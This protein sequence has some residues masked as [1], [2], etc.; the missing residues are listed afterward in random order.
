MVYRLNTNETLSHCPAHPNA[1]DTNTICV[2]EPNDTENMSD[3]ILDVIITVD[4]VLLAHV[5][6]GRDEV[7]LA[8]ACKHAATVVIRNKLSKVPNLV[9]G[10]FDFEE[11]FTVLVA[12]FV[13]MIFTVTHLTYS[14]NGDR[15]NSNSDEDADCAHCMVSNATVLL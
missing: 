12:R 5:T 1:G 11:E 4:V 14:V 9:E 3:N 2:H 6:S 8:D 13:H 15:G 7:V 10:F